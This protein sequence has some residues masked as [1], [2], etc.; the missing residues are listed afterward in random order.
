MG[1]IVAIGGG[2]LSAGETLPIDRYIVSLARSESPRLL[3]IPTASHDSAGYIE[4]FRA[5]YTPLGCV[6]DTLC[7]YGEE[8]DDGIRRKVLTADIIYVGGGN[9]EAM[10]ELWRSR[11]VD[12]YLRQA[13]RAG[14]V[15]SGLSAGS[16]CWF[17]AGHSDSE[18]IAGADKPAYKWVRGLG[19]LPFL[20]C[21]HYNEPERQDF[22]AFF[23][24]QAADAVAL[25]NNTAFVE[26]DGEYFVIRS[27]PSARAV[28]LSWD[29]HAVQRRELSGEKDCCFARGANEEP[30]R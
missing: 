14:T 10:M 21:P 19:F 20:H 29:G 28:L 8:S 2:D 18:F 4:R 24:G 30:H 1:R 11:S 22:D 12:R 6:V 16:I 5:A 13:Y 25:E 3:F 9:T 17:I 27:D 7:L 15:L 26:L 23:A